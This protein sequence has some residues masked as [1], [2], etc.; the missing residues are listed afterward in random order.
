MSDSDNNVPVAGCDLSSWS[1]A[2]SGGTEP[3]GDATA[4]LTLPDGLVLAPGESLVISAALEPSL[5]FGFYN[6]EEFTGMKWWPA[7][8]ADMPNQQAWHISEA[9]QHYIN[10]EGAPYGFSNS[11]FP[12]VAQDMVFALHK[13]TCTGNSLGFKSSGTG[14]VG[15]G[16]V[17]DGP[18]PPITGDPVNL[19]RRHPPGDSASL[20]S[21]D[22]LV[23][24]E[25]PYGTVTPGASTV[26]G[27]GP[28]FSELNSLPNVENQGP[29]F[30]EIHC[31]YVAG[32]GI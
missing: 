21:W 2:Q 5:F 32:E 31:P 30:V 1:V 3:L 9:G 20:E 25:S 14:S 12:R 13:G 27:E 16:A 28:V 23:G 24:K 18:T 15:S 4:C 19:T 29:H 17:I 8:W 11:V 6:L 22:V 26:G 10:V 7:E